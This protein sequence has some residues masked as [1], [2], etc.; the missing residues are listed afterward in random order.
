VT[1]CHGV[2]MCYRLVKIELELR[3]HGN[4]TLERYSPGAF[5]TSVSARINFI[6]HHGYTV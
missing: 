4:C 5:Y 6:L 1:S 3:E 2:G